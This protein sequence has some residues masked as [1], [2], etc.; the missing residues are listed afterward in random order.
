MPKGGSSY[1]L[2]IVTPKSALLSSLKVYLLNKLFFFFFRKA[3][4]VD[5]LLSSVERMKGEPES[6]RYWFSTDVLQAVF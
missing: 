5:D 6:Q 1:V 3:F 4:K 2:I